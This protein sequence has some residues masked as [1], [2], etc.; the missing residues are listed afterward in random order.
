MDR[1]VNPRRQIWLAL[2]TAAGELRWACQQLSPKWRAIRDLEAQLDELRVSL[3]GTTPDGRP[4]YT[5]DRSADET[6]DIIR[7]EQRRRP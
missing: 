3:R 2:R 7:L 6:A 4:A 1:V 5:I